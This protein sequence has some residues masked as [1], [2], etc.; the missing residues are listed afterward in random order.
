MY[1]CVGVTAWRLFY[2]RVVLNFYIV[3]TIVMLLLTNAAL[4]VLEMLVVVLEVGVVDVG[5]CTYV[6]VM[7]FQF[8]AIYDDDVVVYPCVVSWILM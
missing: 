7:V 1:A 5:V 2:I 6:M 8:P 4:E 3:A